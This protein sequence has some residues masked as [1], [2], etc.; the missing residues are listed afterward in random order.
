V[1]RKVTWRSWA[2]IAVLVG[3][4][5]LA[6]FRW[7]GNGR[8][9]ADLYATGLTAAFCAPFV[10]AA[11]YTAT[12]NKWWRN[13]VGTSLVLVTFAMLPIAGPLALTFWF[14]GGVLTTSVMA[15]IEIGGPFASALLLCWLSFVWLRIHRDGNGAAGEEGE[16]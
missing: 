13:D 4:W 12:G 15:W 2:V 1:L 6:G 3:L 10:F 9:S 7:S 16:P 5:V 14:W 11:V 8:V